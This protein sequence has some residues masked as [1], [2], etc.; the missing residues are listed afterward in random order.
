MNYW[1][2]LRNVGILLTAVFGLLFTMV[3]FEGGFGGGKKDVNLM[4]TFLGLAVLGGCIWVF[5]HGAMKKS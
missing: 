5:S 3:L 1:N 2:G 4:F